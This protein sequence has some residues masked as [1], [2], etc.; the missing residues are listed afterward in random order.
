[1]A[2]SSSLTVF[3]GR[4]WLA[5]GQLAVWASRAN[6]ASR[7][8]AWQALIWGTRAARHGSGALG[9]VARRIVLGL[10]GH[11]RKDKPGLSLPGA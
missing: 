2:R 11:R 8:R 4:Y 1:M 9:R 10:V 3:I 5:R 7:C 6:D